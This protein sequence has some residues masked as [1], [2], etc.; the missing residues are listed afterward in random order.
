MRLDWPP[1]STNPA[2]L[3]SGVRH[4]AGSVCRLLQKPDQRFDSQLEVLQVKL[5]V[6]R[7]Q[8]VVRQAEAH[9]HAGQAE[10]PVKVAHNGDRSA[11]ADEDRVLAPHFVQRPRG[12]L[13]VRIVDGNQARDRRSESA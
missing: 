4:E 6:G 11:R 8:V 9:H 3:G 13:D 1:A 2:A 10:M 12:R 7:V 5:L